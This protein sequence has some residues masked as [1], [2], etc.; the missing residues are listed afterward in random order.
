L[1]SLLYL[2]L[3]GEKV[4]GEKAVIMCEWIKEMEE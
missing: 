2:D 3:C 4:N 1:G